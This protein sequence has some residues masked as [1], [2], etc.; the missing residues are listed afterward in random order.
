M[1]LVERFLTWMARPPHVQHECQ[2][3]NPGI[4]NRRRPDIR[5]RGLFR[6][7]FGTGLLP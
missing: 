1:K 7:L 4:P 3:S 5:S 2:R 6:W